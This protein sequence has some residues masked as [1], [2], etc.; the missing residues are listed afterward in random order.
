MEEAKAEEAEAAARGGGEVVTLTARW[1]SQGRKLPARKS[2]RCTNG[3][4]ALVFW[5]GRACETSMT[6]FW[7]E[8]DEGAC[9]PSK[10]GP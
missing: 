3:C 6:M 1:R 7:L 9:L 10:A 2:G 8:I 4:A 5:S